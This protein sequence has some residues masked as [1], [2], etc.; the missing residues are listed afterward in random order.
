MQTVLPKLLACVPLILGRCFAHAQIL[1][2]PQAV[3]SAP[4]ASKSAQRLPGNVHY[5]GHC[6]QTLQQPQLGVQVG[7]HGGIYPQQ[8]ELLC[9]KGLLSVPV[10]LLPSSH[11]SDTPG[12]LT[13]L[14]T[15]LS[16]FL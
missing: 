12:S 5:D 16:V 11:L 6:V 8:N 9:K 2:S 7:L 14:T 1:T 3:G 10:T 13:L 4:A 15:F